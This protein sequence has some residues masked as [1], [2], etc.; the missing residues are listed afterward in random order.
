LEKCKDYSRL[1][2]LIIKKVPCKFEVEF[3]ITRNFVI[4]ILICFILLAN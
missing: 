3:E 2:R 4:L 1:Q